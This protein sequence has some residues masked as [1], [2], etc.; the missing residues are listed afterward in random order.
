M[1]GESRGNGGGVPCGVYPGS[2]WLAVGLMVV[3]LG[4]GWG[5]VLEL[6]R[7]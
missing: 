4:D 2:F 3:G 6:D 7:G 1:G 5:I